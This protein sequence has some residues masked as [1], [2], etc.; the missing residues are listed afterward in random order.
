MATELRRFTDLNQSELLSLARSCR[1]FQIG[2][3]GSQT[4]I[5]VNLERE[6][7]EEIRWRLSARKKQSG[8]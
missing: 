2:H 6:I 3:E 5:C 7:R 8:A 4:S 1:Y